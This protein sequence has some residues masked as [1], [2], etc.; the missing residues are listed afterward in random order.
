MSCRARMDIWVSIVRS[1]K[2]RKVVAGMRVGG[3]VC[4]FED[5]GA[6]EIGDLCAITF[7]FK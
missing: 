7:G 6:F 5:A 1:R 2:M 3:L 4:C